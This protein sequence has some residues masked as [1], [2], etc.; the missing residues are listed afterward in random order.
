VQ[1][2][3]FKTIAKGVCDNAFL[4]LLIRPGDHEIAKEFIQ[5]SNLREEQYLLSSAPHH[6]MVGYLNA[7][8]YSLLIRK[9]HP[10]N[11]AAVPSKFTEAS[12]CGLP[13]I[14]SCEIGDK[15]DELKSTNLLPVLDNY[16]DT[17][18]IISTMKKFLPPSW[19]R[20]EEIREKIAM[21]MLSTERFKNRM[22][23]FMENI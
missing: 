1:F 12:A 22:Q 2:I 17:D 13:T 18:E 14:I 21:Q 7:A 23:R 6:Q 20:R 16:R 10:M 5:K 4:L 3:S 19:E 15:I 11:A 9:R 8:D